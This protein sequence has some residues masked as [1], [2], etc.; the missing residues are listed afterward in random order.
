MFLEDYAPDVVPK[1]KPSIFHRPTQSSPEEQMAYADLLLE[2]GSTKKAA[3]QYRALVHKW[4]DSPQAVSAQRAYAMILEEREKHRKA[5]DEYQYL[6][7]Y[8]PGQFNCDEIVERQ[9]RIA[10]Y[11]KTEKVGKFL[12][13]PGFKAPERAVPLF[14]KI[15]ENAPSWDRCT[16]VQFN[17]AVILDEA[18]RYM[19]ALDAYEVIAAVYPDSEY[20]GEAAFGKARCCYVLSEKASYDERSAREAISVLSRFLR[21][22]P[23]NKNVEQAG[24]YLESLKDRLAGM[25]YERAVFYDRKA[26]KPEAAV[27]AYSDF[28][29][30]FPFSEKAGEV[31]NRIKELEAELEKKNE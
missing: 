29:T 8:Y 11:L 9:F 23:D 6:F 22:Y 28:L 13:L 14:E 1:K 10:N 21:D 16:E 31:N 7:D 4:H 25:Y 26:K 20:A 17:I 30:R 19:D 2:K 27:I 5:F 12:F 18:G 15:V 24:E 3:K